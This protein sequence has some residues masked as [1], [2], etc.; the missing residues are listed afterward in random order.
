MYLKHL[1]Q[2]LG[3]PDLKLLLFIL[4]RQSSLFQ[5]WSVLSFARRYRYMHVDRHLRRNEISLPVMRSWFGIFFFKYVLFKSTF[6]S[7]A[8]AF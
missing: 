4:K 1:F 6:V 3:H 5:S 2:D 7:H 8:P